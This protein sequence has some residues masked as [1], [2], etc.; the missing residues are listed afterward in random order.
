MVEHAKQASKMFSFAFPAYQGIFAFENASNHVFFADD[1]LIADKMNLLPGGNQPKRRD[2]FFWNGTHRRPQRMIF[3]S[4]S[5]QFGIAK[6]AKG[7]R[8][9]VEGKRQVEGNEFVRL[10]HP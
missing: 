4:Y 7:H 9:G 5:S 1:A 8:A 2:T 6:P 10:R 3:A